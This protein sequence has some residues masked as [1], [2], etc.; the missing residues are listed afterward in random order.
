MADTEREEIIR[1]YRENYSKYWA[2]IFDEIKTEDNCIW[3]QS[4]SGYIMKLNGTVIGMDIPFRAQWV[5]DLVAD[6]CRKDAECFDYYILSHEHI[7]HFCPNFLPELSESTE[8]LVP[9]FFSDEQLALYTHNRK[10]IQKIQAN[11]VYTLGNVD[12]HTFIGNHFRP[13]GNGVNEFGYMFRAGDKKLLFPVDMR[14]YKKPLPNFGNIDVLF[15]H[16][17]F[18]DDNTKDY[19]DILLQQAEFIVKTAPKKVVLAHLD[20]FERP[21]HQRWSKSHARELKQKVNELNSDIEVIIPNVG[22]AISIRN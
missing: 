16:V 15:A 2:K 1:D 13:D 22:D 10:N 11:N 12:I 20:D 17:W 7:D 19:S 5:K 21:A 6:R 18:C 8:M 14:D 4:P 3:L 9:E